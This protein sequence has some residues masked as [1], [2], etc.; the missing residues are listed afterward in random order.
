[1]RD[2]DLD[3]TPLDSGVESLDRSL[4]QDGLAP[5]VRRLGEELDRGGT[6]GAAARGRLVYAAGR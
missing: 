3:T 1:M 4:R 6:D 2:D 5:L